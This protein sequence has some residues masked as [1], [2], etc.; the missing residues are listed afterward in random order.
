MNIFFYLI[1]YYNINMIYN[2]ILQSVIGVDINGGEKFFYDWS[3][4]EDVPYKVSFSFTCT[5]FNNT[6]LNNAI[7]YVDLGQVQNNIAQAQLAS[8]SILK[9]N[10]LGFL[11]NYGTGAGAW[12]QADTNLNPP[13]YIT[14]RPRN[15]NFS[16]EIQNN[17]IATTD[18]APQPA[19]Y[20]LIL[21]FEKI[22]K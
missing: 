12:L 9:G 1:V 17:N 2:V 5:I 4:L 18:F 15:N 11:Q 19:Q 13:T 16:V 14:G 7:L 6:G 8:S 20:T 10:Y 3:Q 21:S 22:P